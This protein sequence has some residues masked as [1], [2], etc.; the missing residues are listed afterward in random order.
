M[1]VPSPKCLWVFAARRAERGCLTP[2]AMMTLALPLPS[3]N[4]KA[5]GVKIDTPRR[6]ADGPRIARI[7]Q[8]WRALPLVVE[9]VAQTIQISTALVMVG[10]RLWR[11]GLVGLVFPISEG[12]WVS[13][14]GVIP[15]TN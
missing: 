10:E 12:E 13:S 8:T 5:G 9:A 1:R 14:A 15:P 3:A 11:F 2:A 6:R 4:G 7:R